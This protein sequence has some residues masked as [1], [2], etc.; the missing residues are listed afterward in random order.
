MI[1]A[2]HSLICIAWVGV[3][4]DVLPRPHI[5]G[6]VARNFVLGGGRRGL[7][8]EASCAKIEML[9]ASRVEAMRGVSSWPYGITQCYLPPYT[10]ELTPP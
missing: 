9:K 1:L 3:V 6:V 5:I 7:R 4:I 8:I 10:S 2:T